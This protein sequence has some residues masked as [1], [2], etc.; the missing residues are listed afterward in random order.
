MKQNLLHLLLKSAKTLQNELRIK[1]K[2]FL[3]TC[4]IA[5]LSEFLQTLP[6]DGAKFAS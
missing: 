4:K 5:N 3:I 6:V 1:I 2:Y